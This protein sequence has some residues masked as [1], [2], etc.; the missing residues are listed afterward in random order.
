MVSARGGRIWVATQGRVYLHD[1]ALRRRQAVDLPGQSAGPHGPGA[2]PQAAQEVLGLI[3][4][5]HGVW[6]VRS[7]SLVFVGE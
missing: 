7:G 1:D 3:P 4:T 5:A 6:L 2:G